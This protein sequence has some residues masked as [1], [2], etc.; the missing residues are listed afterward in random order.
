MMY[1]WVR[2]IGIIGWCKEITNEDGAG[3]RIVADTGIS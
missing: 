1:R 3:D 2:L